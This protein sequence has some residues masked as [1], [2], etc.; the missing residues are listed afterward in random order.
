MENQWTLL[1]EVIK[2]P[3]ILLYGKPGTGKT[4]SAMKLGMRKNKPRKSI[5]LTPETT[6]TDLVGH[7]ILAG[8]NGMV[9]NDGVAVQMWKQGGRLVINEI[10]HAGQD[11]SSILHALLDDVEF[12]EMTLPNEEK[13]IVRPAK[14]FQVIATMNGE[15]E[16]LSEALRDRFPIKINIDT[17]HPQAIESLTPKIAS[18][19]QDIEGTDSSIRSFMELD[20]LI[21]KQGVG[22]SESF[23]ETMVEALTVVDSDKAFTENEN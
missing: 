9:W 7:Y 16:D 2:S 1:E 19:M 3:R 21:N 13:E 4:Y 12:A 8:N 23:A 15:P 20:R 6:A 5:T 18:V 22:A 17:I 10:D 14:G 11:V